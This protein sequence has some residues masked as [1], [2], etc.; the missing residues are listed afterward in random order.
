[1]ESNHKLGEFTIT[2]LANSASAFAFV[3]YLKY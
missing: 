1:M 2:D 3:I